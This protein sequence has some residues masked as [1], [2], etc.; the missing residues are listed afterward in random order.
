MKHIYGIV[1]IFMDM[2]SPMIRTTVDI[3][4]PLYKK[5]KEQ[6]VQQGCSIRDLLV[7]GVE[8]V[9]LNPQRPRKRAIRFPLIDSPG[10]KVAMTNEQIYEH[11]EFP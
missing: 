7:S 8:R 6:A 1:A 3:P 5:L 4:A 9:L 2:E 11:I 10:P